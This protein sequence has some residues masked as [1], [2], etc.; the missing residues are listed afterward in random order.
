MWNKVHWPPGHAEVLTADSQI[1]GLNQER[2]DLA[3]GSTISNEVEVP[4][5]SF[6]PGPDISSPFSCRVIQKLKTKIVSSKN[7]LTDEPVASSGLSKHPDTL[8]LSKFWT[9]FIRMNFK[10]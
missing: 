7:T 4:E 8:I 10:F 5:F 2:G 6:N 9:V 3:G 1:S